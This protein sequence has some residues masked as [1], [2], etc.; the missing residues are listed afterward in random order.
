MPNLIILKT[1]LDVWEAMTKGPVIVDG[2]I[3]KVQT[4]IA[5]VVTLLVTVIDIGNDRAGQT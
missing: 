4:L 1:N 2:S 5:K 3:Q